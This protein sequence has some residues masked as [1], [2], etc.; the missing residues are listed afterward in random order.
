MDLQAERDWI[1]SEIM[2]VRDP[3]LIIA[4]KSMLKYSAKHIEKD[5][6]D[7]ISEEERKEIQQGIKDIESGNFVSH[8]EAM[9]NARKW[10]QK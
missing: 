8:Q 10:H 9:K 1:A 6:W 5:W 4:F 7:E 3:E 2:K